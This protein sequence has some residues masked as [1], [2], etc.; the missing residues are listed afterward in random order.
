M[1]IVHRLDHWIRT[2]IDVHYLIVLIT[3]ASHLKQQDV[4]IRLLTAENN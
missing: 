1:I 4:N 2:S 3:K